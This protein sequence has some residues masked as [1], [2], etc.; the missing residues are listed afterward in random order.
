MEAITKIIEQ[1]WA[2]LLK[3]LEVVSVE[4]ETLMLKT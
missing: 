4:L 3:D 1:H 2:K